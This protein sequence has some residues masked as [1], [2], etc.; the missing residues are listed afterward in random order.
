MPLVVWFSRITESCYHDQTG[1]WRRERS[2]SPEGIYS[3]VNVLGPLRRR[4][5][6]VLAIYASEAR[7]VQIGR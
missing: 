4:A 5:V 6:F 1:E 3:E 7:T 2:S